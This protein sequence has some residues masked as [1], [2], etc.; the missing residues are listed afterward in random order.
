MDESDRSMV[1]KQHEW[2]GVLSVAVLSSF[3][4]LLGFTYSNEE[5]RQSRQSQQ[6]KMAGR[7][8]ALFSMWVIQLAKFTSSEHKKTA[9]E[10]VAWINT[11][12]GLS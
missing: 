2:I 7:L 9:A 4:Q 1:Q 11:R 3:P 5:K 8:F 10:V 12:H 6:G